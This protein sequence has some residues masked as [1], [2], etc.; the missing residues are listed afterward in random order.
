MSLSHISFQRGEVWQTIGEVDNEENKEG[1]PLLIVSRDDLNRGDTV[2]AVP[3]YS[4][5]LEKRKLLKWCVFF[6]RG[7]A[8]L[9]KDC[10][11]KCDEI[12]FYD[13]LD[14]DW[15]HGKLG[16]MNV[17]EMNAVAKAIRYVIRDDVS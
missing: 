5:Q 9:R 2:V 7:I 4:Q 3:F 6:K 17:D 11:A 1:R 14:I 16:R 8:G 13:K 12:A 15:R 10:V